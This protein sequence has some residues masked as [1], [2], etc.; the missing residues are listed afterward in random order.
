MPALTAE[1]NA[2]NAA[3]TTSH[4]PHDG[5]IASAAVWI[6]ARSSWSTSD[7]T[8]AAVTSMPSVQ[9]AVAVSSDSVRPRGMRNDGSSTSSAALATLVRPP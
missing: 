9:S 4:A 2:A 5:R 1:A 3:T 7:G 6:G 8:T